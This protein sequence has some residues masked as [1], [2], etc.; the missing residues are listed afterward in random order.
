M[1]RVHHAIHWGDSLTHYSQLPGSRDGYHL[2]GVDWQKDHYAFYVD[3]KPAWRV[4]EAVSSAPQFL[5]L[6]AE[7]ESGLWDKRY[8]LKQSAGLLPDAWHV[9]YVRVYQRRAEL[10]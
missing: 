9:D 7:M 10:P 3:G 5:M 1:G 4:T 8:S 6:T 2:F